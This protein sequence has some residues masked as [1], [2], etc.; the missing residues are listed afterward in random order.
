[1][2]KSWVWG[3]AAAKWLRASVW[4]AVLERPTPSL[5]THHPLLQLQPLKK[6]FP[7]RSRSLPRCWAQ[8]SVALSGA[9]TPPSP[10]CVWT[11]QR[12][13]T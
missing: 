9:R 7:G 11:S 5:S 13:P 12:S 3:D 8:F 4:P 10:G 6:P 2:G 1:M